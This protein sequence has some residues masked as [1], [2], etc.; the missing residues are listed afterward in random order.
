MA[1]SLR[2]IIGPNI[3]SNDTYP[4]VILIVQQHCVRCWV[5]FSVGTC[6]ADWS[7]ASLGPGYCWE[8]H[9]E[10]AFILLP[11]RKIPHVQKV[12]AISYSNDHSVLLLGY[13]QFVAL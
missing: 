7:A 5:R 3:I 1:N 2:V 8:L 4:L 12:F 13:M 9:I 10:A 11:Q 6:A